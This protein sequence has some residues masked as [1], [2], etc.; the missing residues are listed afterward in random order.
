MSDDDAESL[1]AQ[2]RALARFGEFALSSDDLG[3]ILHTACEHVRNGLNSD[4][5]KVVELQPD[6]SSFV[7]AAGVGWRP[8]VV[9]HATSSA[10]PETFE[11]E[12]VRTR[13]PVVCERLTQDVLGRVAPFVR[14]HGVLSFVNVNI[15]AP[16]SEKSYGLLEVDYR[17]ARIFSRSDIDFLRTYA[18]L[19]AVVI[20]RLRASSDLRRKADE[21][22][23][24]LQELRHRSKNNLQLLLSLV[25]FSAARAKSGEAREAL[26][27]VSDRIRALS[28]IQGKLHEQREQERVELGQYLAEIVRSL[29]HFSGRSDAV[30]VETDIREVEV[31]SSTAL[32]LGLVAN[33]FVTNSLKHAFPAGAGVI[34]VAVGP[35]DRDWTRV[36][37][38][39]NGKGLAAQAGAGTGMGLIRALAKS[40]GAELSWQGETG[41]RL[42]IVIPQ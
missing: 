30:Q 38:F 6:E 18:N 22:A 4:L 31:A 15:L 5:A 7:V 34:G 26:M 32:N 41:L 23:H 33:E 3:E 20:Q 11:G 29:V 1:L 13:E 8:G 10:T 17:S 24:L 12:A 2:Q 37:L 21:N 14:E 27:T 36:V 39:D 40:L 35:L 28:T 9:G 25:S 42:E 16:E 19:I